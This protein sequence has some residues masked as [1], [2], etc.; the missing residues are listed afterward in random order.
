MLSEEWQVQERA[1]SAS[2]RRDLEADR[3][4]NSWSPGIVSISQLRMHKALIESIVHFNFIKE[5]KGQM[6][7][8]KNNTGTHLVTWNHC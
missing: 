4:R 6:E 7:T 1:D 8:M 5:G 2:E 3:P